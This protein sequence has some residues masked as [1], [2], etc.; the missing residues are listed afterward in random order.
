MKEKTKIFPICPENKVTPNDDNSDFMK[1]IKPKNYT[2]T[3]KLKCAWT[4]KKNFLIHYRMLI[5]CLRHVMIVDKIREVISIKQSK[6]SETK[7]KFQ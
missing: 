1:K 6:W 3:K 2:E 5:F 4:D 7:Y